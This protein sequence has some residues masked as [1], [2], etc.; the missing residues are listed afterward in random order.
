MFTGIVEELGR[1]EAI[2]SATAAG[3]A[4]WIARRVGAST[5]LRDRRQHRRQRLL[6]DRRSRSRRRPLRGRGRA[7][8][9]APHH[10]GALVEGDAVNLERP[11]RL[12]ERLGGH[13]VQGH[14]DGVGECAAVREEPPGGGIDIAAAA[15][16]RCA[17][18]RARARSPSTASSLTVARVETATL[19]ASRSSRTRSQATVCRVAP[20][21]A[22]ES[23]SGPAGALP[24]APARGGPMKTRTRPRGVRRGRKPVRRRAPTPAARRREGRLAV[25]RWRARSPPAASAA[26]ADAPVRDAA[27]RRRRGRARDIRARPHGHRRGRRRPR[28]RGRHHVRGREGHRRA[29][30]LRGHARRAA[31]CARRWRREAPSRLGLDP[32]GRASNTALHGT[33][34]TESVDARARH[35]HRH[36]GVRPRATHRGG[37]PIRAGRAGRLRAPGPRLPAA[38]GAA[39]ACCAAPGTPRRSPDLCRLAGL[40]AG[41]RAVRDPR[42]RRPHDAAAARCSASRAST[43]S[44]SS[45]SAT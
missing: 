18:S 14:V 3:A 6:P 25:R 5:D 36:L 12:E 15:G 23:R 10:L 21:H 39:A 17:T 7:R 32:D 31:S 1:I 44:A 35:D 24:G 30:Q 8:D 13:L 22:S 11:L 9:A 26:R 29:G 4:S 43:G 37:S 16:A 45:P 40:R 19:R 33:P 41:R 42:R 20:G 2:E 27:V 34:F 28:E 38:R